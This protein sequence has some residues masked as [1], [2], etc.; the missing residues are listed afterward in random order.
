MENMSGTHA[1]TFRFVGALRFVCGGLEKS[2]NN[3]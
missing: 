3:K 1:W 2:I